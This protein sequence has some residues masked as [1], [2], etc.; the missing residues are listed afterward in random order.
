MGPGMM[1]PGQ[2]N[3]D[4]TGNDGEG[5][6]DPAGRLVT[7]IQSNGLTC[8]ACHAISG[9]RA[10]PDFTGIGQRYAGASGAEA[11]LTQ[12]IA[13]G[14]AGKWPGYPPMPGGQASSRQAADLANLIL[15][16]GR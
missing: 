4:W 5:A 15:Q 7:Y 14:V 12:S 3:G 10:G 2:E 9:R 8:L 16:L 11:T 1:R 13:N 6:G